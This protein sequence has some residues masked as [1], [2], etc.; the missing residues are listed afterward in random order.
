MEIQ[1]SDPFFLTLSSTQKEQLVKE[2]WQKITTGSIPSGSIFLVNEG[3]CK[4]KETGGSIYPGILSGSLPFLKQASFSFSVEEGSAFCL[5]GARFATFLRTHPMLYFQYLNDAKNKGRKAIES[6]K[7]KYPK[8]AL[9]CDNHTLDKP[10]LQS[11]LQNLSKKSIVIDITQKG[12]NLFEK[13]NIP[14]PDPALLNDE[15][16]HAESARRSIERSTTVFSEGG[17]VLMNLQFLSPYTCSA[18]EWAILLH[19]L[20]ETYDQVLLVSNEVEEQWSNSAQTILLSKNLV[21]KM[22]KVSHSGYWSYFEN[23]QQANELL[24]TFWSFSS[25][26]LHESMN[27]VPE[28]ELDIQQ[29]P[30]LFP[31]AIA[32]YHVP[33]TR[34]MYRYIQPVYPRKHFLKKKKSSEIKA[35][36]NFFLPYRQ[37]NRLKIRYV[38]TG[39]SF[40]VT[41]LYLSTLLKLEKDLPIGCHG[42]DVNSIVQQFFGMHNI[43][44]R[45]YSEK[46]NSSFPGILASNFSLEAYKY[47]KVFQKR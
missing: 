10:G 18:I 12:T 14:A 19:E 33:D 25:T 24:S 29:L 42:T 16:E 36:L 31:S 22:D 30:L 1:F 39:Q 47:G 23:L 7:N 34:A 41:A 27:E 40:P 8:I 45:I 17:P 4:I 43:H 3:V 21:N 44:I 6:E 20:K 2:P 15:S 26:G 46:S 28:E 9:L 13:L 38:L 32:D 37:N 11:I 5:S 35:K